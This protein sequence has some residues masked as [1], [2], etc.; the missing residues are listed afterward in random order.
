MKNEYFK[1]CPGIAMLYA[2]LLVCL[3]GTV[4]ADKL[5][6]YRVTIDNLS[7]QSFLPNVAFTHDSDLRMYK[8]QRT[9]SVGL[10]VIDDNGN[11]QS[12]MFDHL[13]KHRHVTEVIDIGVPLAPKE[14]M[15]FS[16][17]ARPGNR[18]SLASM[19][20]CTNNGFTGLNRARLPKRG[21]EILWAAGMEANTE[22]STD[23]AEPCSSFVP[24][25][26][27]DYPYGNEIHTVNTS[28]PEQ[29]QF[30]SNIRDAGDK[31]VGDHGWTGT[32]AKITVTLVSDDANKFLARL[33]SDGEVPP[34]KTGNDAWGQADLMLNADDTELI[35]RLKALRMK[36][37]VIQAR[38]HQGLPNDNGPVV[39]HLFE[40]SS[41]TVN[42][43][44]NT[45]G[46][47]THS[48][49]VGPLAGDF[50]GFVNAL[51]AGELYINVHSNEYPLGEIRGQVGIN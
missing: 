2:L 26:L 32:A 15:T 8:K 3:P 19:V 17:T 12:S 45:R 27:P 13:Y 49:L 31:T 50:K 6:H 43:H 7:E 35:Y 37:G 39:A 40:P 22:L 5:M 10:D 9:A 29:L 33:S 25:T 36:S 4:H 30:H 41:P 47:L 23:F 38:I 48:E 21:A 51:R 11:Q 1:P 14:S 24:G 46:R 18:L 16:I 28:P 34:I 44:L 20:V 42:E